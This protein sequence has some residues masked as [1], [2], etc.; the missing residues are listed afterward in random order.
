MAGSRSGVVH[1]R[2]HVAL[3]SGG[4][5]RHDGEG[6]RAVQFRRNSGG[7]GTF[8]C[9]LGR[10]GVRSLAASR[11]RRAGVGA[12]ATNWGRR[13]GAGAAALTLALALARVGGARTGADRLCLRGRR[14]AAAVFCGRGRSGVTTLGDRAHGR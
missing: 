8:F 3:V 14:A 7:S 2:R 11:G 1:R 6:D 12:F 5:D 10:A 13:V 9:L 4:W